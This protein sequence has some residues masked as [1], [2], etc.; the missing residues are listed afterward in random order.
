MLPLLGGSPSVWNTCLMFFQTLLLLG[1]LYA[2]AS[3]R[4]LSPRRQ[5]TLH[6]VLLAACVVMLPPGIPA[7]WD[8][9]ASGNVIPWLILVLTVSLGPPF[10]V[11]SA[12]A[13]LL[14]RWLASVDEPVKN[15]YVLYA[16]SNAGSFIGLL[17]FPL[18]FEPNLRLSDQ[19]RLWTA[20][21]VAAALLVAGCGILALRRTSVRS[22]ERAGPLADSPP[23]TWTTRLKWIALAFVPS[24]LLLSVTTYLTTDVAATPLLWVIPLSLYLLSFVIVFSGIAERVRGPAA[25]LHAVAVLVLMF[26]LFW[27]ISLGFQRAYA[28]HLSVFALTALVLHGELAASRPPPARLTE[29]Y[30]WM[31]FGGALGGAFTA[32]VVP[33]VFE[34]TRDYLAML[35]I[36]CFLRP[37][38]KRASTAS[39]LSIVGVASVTI[40][41]LI[42]A[43]VYK[44]DIEDYSFLGTS[45]FWITTVVAGGVVLSI[46]KVPP[47]FGL[48]VA[49]IAIAGIAVQPGRATLYSDR[50][51]FGI[52]RVARATGPV[53]ILYHGTTIHGAQFTDSARRLIPITYYHPSG[54][55]GQVFMELAPEFTDRDI[56]IVGLGT[57]SILCYARPGQRWTFFEIDPNVERIARNDSL[58]TFLSSC[59]VQP[60]MVFGDARLTLTKE[61]HG[62]YALLVLDAF[63]SDAIPV[64]L[65]T[66]EAIALYERLLTDRG[67]LMLHISNRR[68]DL[69][70]V[71]ADLAA[72]AGLVALLRN[73][74]VPNQRQD[75][76]YDYGSDWVVLA[77]SEEHL[78]KLTTDPLWTKLEPTG[79]SRPWTDDYSNIIGVIRW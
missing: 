60:R 57:G 42:L 21:Y 64:H 54:P 27:Q 28:L 52:Y 35:V 66:R 68:L 37:G 11:L 62:T 9:P 44:Y 31:A 56:G 16:A 13:P 58:F 33:V 5:V 29:F 32:L 59:P 53:N 45:L 47:R 51:F 20:V 1:Y 40:P 79:N 48:A 8:P 75:S 46:R 70:P 30:L 61:P 3:T 78:G 4:L 38:I 72:D 22:A 69:E 77:R 39:T 49:A 55:V 76:A 15:P 24:S 17:A 23:P 26:V 14:Q 2:H 19:S 74:E 71:V 41:A 7:G 43:L 65:L 6:I 63:S 36:A 67:V 73:H 34:S 50:S 12:T 18:L 10:I 25:F